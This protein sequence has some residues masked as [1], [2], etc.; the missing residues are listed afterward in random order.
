MSLGV[1]AGSGT[2]GI[3][4]KGMLADSAA[5]TVATSRRIATLTEPIIFDS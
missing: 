5:P 3:G 4:E 1:E 2:V